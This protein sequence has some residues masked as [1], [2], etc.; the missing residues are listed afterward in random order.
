MA[1]D[2]AIHCCRDHSRNCYDHL[3]AG[4][5]Y[6]LEETL[7]GSE[8]RVER[9]FRRKK[10][11]TTLLCRRCRA[12]YDRQYST[13]CPPETAAACHL[14]TEIP[15]EEPD[16]LLAS[17]MFDGLVEPVEPLPG[18]V[19]LCAACQEKLRRNL[20]ALGPLAALLAARLAGLFG[21]NGRR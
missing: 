18:L 13:V 11:P 15:A 12:A 5:L 7:L 4:W 9:R 6:R 14:L 21:G 1:V 16:F 19:P 3:P 17:G 2:A 10:T 8:L 20:Q